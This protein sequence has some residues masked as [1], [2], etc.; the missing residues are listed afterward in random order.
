M[1]ARPAIL[2]I[3]LIVTAVVSA[4]VLGF[5]ATLLTICAIV[6]LAIAASGWTVSSRTTSIPAVRPSS[7]DWKSHHE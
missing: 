1:I 2:L 7:A 6:G 3:A 4:D 5:A